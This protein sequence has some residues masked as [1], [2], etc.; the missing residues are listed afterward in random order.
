M[1]SNLERRIDRLE[2]ATGERRLMLICGAADE[3][4]EQAIAAHLVERPQDAGCEFCVV[5]TGVP[6]QV[7][8]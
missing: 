4:S 8:A 6:R 1:P 3:T 7:A 5:I 2:Q